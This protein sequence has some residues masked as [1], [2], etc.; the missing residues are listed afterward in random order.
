MQSKGFFAKRIIHL[1]LT[2][3]M[4]LGPLPGNAQG[5][6]LSTLPNPGAMVDKSS[7]FVP[8][9]VK[10]LIIHPDK[11][12][13]LDLIVDS[14]NDSVDPAVIS[15][16][17]SRIAKYFLAAV[18]V[19]QDNLWVNLS[20][21]EKD[22]VIEDELAR[23]LLGRDMLAQDYLLKQLASSLLYPENGLGK[24]FWA[25][26]YKE[27]K[28]RIGTTDIPVDTFNKVWILPEKA[29]VFEK[30]NAVY[31]TKARL[32]VMLD[33]DRVAMKG[34]GSADVNDEKARIA[35]A[36]MRE[37]IIP[38]IESEVN[39]G[40]N[41]ATIRQVYHAAILAKWYREIIQNTLIGDV[42]LGK[43]RV[44]GVTSD[45]KSLKDKIYQRYLAAYSKG[46]FNYVKDDT[47]VYSGEMIA[48]K[49][50]SGGIS[51]F[52]MK[53]IPL[54]RTNDL[55]ASAQPTGQDFKVA[56]KLAPPKT[57]ILTKQE[58]L[59]VKQEKT[60][61]LLNIPGSVKGFDDT[62][63]WLEQLRSRGIKVAVGSSS[64]NAQKVLGNLGILDKF[65]VV[66]DG[67]DIKKGFP[68]KKTPL[69]FAEVAK[70]IGISDPRKAVVVEDAVAG[71]R[72]AKEGGLGLVIGVAREHDEKALAEAGADRVVTDIR[73][74]NVD[75]EILAKYEAVIFD[76]DGVLS[77]TSQL[78][79]E[80]WKEA[81]DELLPAEIKV[82][83]GEFSFEDYVRIMSGKTSYE[84]LNDFLRVRGIDN[85]PAAVVS[86]EQVSVVAGIKG[87]TVL[88]ML[89][90]P[91][92]V[93]GF[94][95]TIR[96]IK[97]LKVHGNRMAVGSASRSAKM[98]LKNLG[99]IDDFNMIV[100]G[101]MAKKN[102]IGPLGEVYVPKKG[103]FG[104][105]SAVASLLGIDPSDCV[106]LE[107]A[108]DGVASAK[109]GGIGLVVGLART[110][111][112]VP[113]LMAAGAD[114]V[115][116][117]VNDLT[118]DEILRIFRSQAVVFDMDGVISDTTFL[119]NTAWKTTLNQ[120][121]SELENVT[122]Q[123]Y[124]RYADEDYNTY[125]NGVDSEV[126]V[127]K[128]LMSR[129]IIL[130][131]DASEL[132]ESNDSNPSSGRGQMLRAV[133]KGIF[134]SAAFKDV[135]KEVSRQLKEFEGPWNMAL[136][137]LQ[138]NGQASVANDL[139]RLLPKI[140]PRLV[141]GYLPSPIQHTGHVV[142]F[143][144]RIGL[145]ELKN[146]S[147]DPTGLKVLLVSALFHDSGLAEAAS[148]VVESDIEL[149][150]DPVQKTRLI[151]EAIRGREDHMVI[152]ERYAYAILQ[153]DKSITRFDLEK[154][155]DI[156]RHHDDMK[157]PALIRRL[158]G[159][160]DAER[161]AK[162]KIFLLKSDKSTNG[163]DWLK[164]LHWE[165]DTL[166]MDCPEGIDVDRRRTASKGGK[167]KGVLSQF[168]FN[169]SLHR[170][171]VKTFRD[172]FDRTSFND[173]F[174]HQG[175][176]YRSDKSFEI[177][178]EYLKKAII[179]LKNEIVEFDSKA[180]YNLLGSPDQVLRDQILEQ[181]RTGKLLF[182]DKEIQL[183]D[184]KG[185]PI[186]VKIDKTLADLLNYSVDPSMNG[187]IDLQNIDVRR[188]QPVV[189]DQLDDTELR[190]V[191][192]DGFNGFSPKI[193]N[194][195]PVINVMPLFG[196]STADQA[197]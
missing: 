169:V 182:S 77:N 97:E 194:I 43:N 197:L 32:K 118:Q 119:H 177:F 180:G 172:V 72:S 1:I 65:L 49:Y 31:I 60:S 129:G 131:K 185:F 93:K 139:K 176:L 67:N 80:T 66:I 28:E 9:L 127:E 68:S 46:V 114:I 154:I 134:L 42:Y 181:F 113:L 130:E 23:T 24:D 90:V 121:L 178:E 174:F 116:A 69:F 10:G 138:E 34:S 82:K 164:Q 128:F 133:K 190:S 15:E 195:T 99:L 37:I 147:I 85:I 22:R 41:F 145:A 124:P 196:V 120:A 107:D 123:S 84:E 63:E 3:S 105:Y 92:A 86:R 26:I 16:E 19:P 151:E 165:A 115:R 79:Y 57:E 87:D 61:T 149:V 132:S 47:D 109:A 152:S 96:L 153:N 70:R 186:P 25:R 173:Y 161:I 136:T 50:F 89:E 102:L 45:E 142:N 110:A 146:G 160:S 14:G 183:S 35:K 143:A 36:V 179:G 148:K 111:T 157:I 170:D 40:R 88:K 20:P 11:P 55:A 189:N 106:V 126:T 6:F 64:K 38:A 104:Y 17:S 62:I 39:E 18:T 184:K 7:L 83:M 73:T 162:S 8:V 166:W 52:A 33:S 117:D 29:E 144:V 108:K 155:L 51:D 100:D 76:M 192:T 140:M 4:I 44:E 81:F 94:D 5:L 53:D 74:I 158:P 122:A 95:S 188:S 48:R 12:L 54:E 137:Q 78:H 125:A 21:F 175:L 91:G 75:N 163:S 193:V 191:L 159:I 167:P 135:R 187:G 59:R 2:V 101:T 56:F 58:L 30:G 150:K 103:D 13:D 71:V 141:Q 171:A 27:A 98:V 156:I 168:F 112:D